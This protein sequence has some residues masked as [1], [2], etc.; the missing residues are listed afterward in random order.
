MPTKSLPV[1]VFIDG[2]SRGNPGPAGVGAVFCDE[3]GKVLAEVSRYLGDA[4]N[5]VAEYM[6]LLYALQE[7]QTRGWAQLAVHSDSELLV[8]QLQGEYKVRD[9]TLRVLYDLARAN[10]RALKQ[11][12]IMHVPRE[13]N[14]HAD[15]L[16]GHAVSAHVRA[17]KHAAH[18]P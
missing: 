12:T 10:I 17:L 5:N 8:K 13:R 3:Q 4:T 2:A 6:A 18:A 14:A 7:A 15:R 11:F 16:A 9:A 1:R